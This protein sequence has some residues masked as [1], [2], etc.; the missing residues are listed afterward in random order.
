MATTQEHLKNI[1]CSPYRFIANEEYVEGVD[2]DYFYTP[3]PLLNTQYDDNIEVVYNGTYTLPALAYRAYKNQFGEDANRLYWVILEFSGIQSIR[4]ISIG[5]KLI[6]PNPN[7]IKA[8][9]K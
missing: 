9:V 2:V 4:D 1:R 3:R 7:R 5:T 8:I 6:F